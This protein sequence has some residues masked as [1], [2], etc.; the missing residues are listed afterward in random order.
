LGAQLIGAAADVEAEG[1][2][3]GGAGGE[4]PRRFR[5]V[6]VAAVVLLQ[7]PGG[8]A[9][10]VPPSPQPAP[11][12]AAH[13]RPPQAHP[14]A[15]LLAR[16]LLGHEMVLVGGLGIP[17]LAGD[18]GHGDVH[19]ASVAFALALEA[20]GGDIEGSRTFLCLRGQSGAGRRG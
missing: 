13:R 2:A 19:P 9:A 7:V 15:P 1:D 5:A 17:A 11:M 4:A 10:W 6:G 8:G 16:V 18:P 14:L 20:A 12:G 3:D